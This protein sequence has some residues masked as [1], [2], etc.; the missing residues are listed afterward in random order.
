MKSRRT[1]PKQLVKALIERGKVIPPVPDSVR[2]RTL[3]RARST[4][5]IVAVE[6]ASRAPAMRHRGLAVALAA[7]VAFAVGAAVA[8][9]TLRSDPPY[10]PATAPPPPP[11]PPAAEPV[12]CATPVPS[13][14][15]SASVALPPGTAPSAERTQRALSAQ[16]S[17]AA[18]LR[19][20]QR[21]QAAYRSEDY[22]AALRLVEEHRQRFPRGRLT[23]E[24]EA[25]RVKALAG[26]GREQEASR[27]AAAFESQYPRSPLLR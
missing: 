21:A 18:E 2:E 17:Y 20:L 19:V 8:A 26:A 24:R 27:A 10:E 4:V 6:A 23:Q 3:A 9:A 5:G 15:A 25:L 7:A 14:P 16:A 11:T 1:R 22:G 13:P 12:P